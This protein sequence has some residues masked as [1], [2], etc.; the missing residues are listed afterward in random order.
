MAQSIGKTIEETASESTCLKRVVVCD[1]YD[2]DGKLLSRE[3]NR[4]TP[5]DGK[6]CRMAIVSQKEGYPEHSTCNWTHAEEMAISALPSGSVPH[7]ANL[8]GH[9]FPCPPCEQ[10][11]MAVGV[12]VITTQPHP[13]TGPREATNAKAN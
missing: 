11:L 6:C 8:Y 12:K 5:P 3:S 1:I 2:V 13:M 10:K 9:D 4:C 7:A